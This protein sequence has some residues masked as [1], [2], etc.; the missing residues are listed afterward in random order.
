MIKLKWATILLCAIELCV[1]ASD[2]LQNESSYSA[3]TSKRYSNYI[4]L[5]AGLT[6]GYGLSY[7]KWFD[8]WAVQV[9]LFPWYEEEKYNDRDDGEYDYGRDSGYSN[10]GYGS[11][12][13][14]YIRSLLESKYIRFCAYGGGNCY[15]EYKK[16]DYYEN[17]Y[18]SNYYYNGDY[19]LRHS[20]GK[21]L[22]NTLSL[23]AGCG[24]EFFIWRFGFHGMAGIRGSNRFPDDKKSLGISGEA[25]VYFRF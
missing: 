19:T 16:Y 5:A 10:N 22:T 20:K 8:K 1:A 15:V 6:S 9:T 23:G 18:Y 13:L 7:K 25:G 21:D 4:G 17:G 24:A 14:M 11:I 3:V 2:S 12:G